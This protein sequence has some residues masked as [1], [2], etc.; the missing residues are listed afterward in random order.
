MT[1]QELKRRI[2]ALVK[3]DEKYL[4][5]ELLIMT[6]SAWGE[7]E[8]KLEDLARSDKARTIT[9]LAEKSYDPS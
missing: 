9:F 1:L 6:E 2:E 5:Y 4:N 7:C 8:Q 3:K